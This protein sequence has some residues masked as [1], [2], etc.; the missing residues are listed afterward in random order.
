[1]REVSAKQTK[2]YLLATSRHFSA[3][4]PTPL[5]GAGRVDDERTGVPSSKLPAP[6]EHLVDEGMR[7]V[8]EARPCWSAPPKVPAG[9]QGTPARPAGSLKCQH[10]CVYDVSEGLRSGSSGSEPTRVCRCLSDFETAYKF[11]FD[12]F[13][14][15]KVRVS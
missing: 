6:L 2:L 14:N 15:I 5:L 9:P 7:E 4:R 11:P 3:I 1:M 12:F 10:A 13:L 8:Y